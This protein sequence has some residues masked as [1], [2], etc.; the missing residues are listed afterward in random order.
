MFLPLQTGIE[1]QIALLV[2]VLII[3]F[4]VFKMMKTIKPLVINA[5]LGLVV[6]LL[7]GIVGFGVK[8]NVVL[9][10]LVAFGGVPAALLAIILAQ[11]GVVF[12]PAMLVPLF[13]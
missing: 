4:G 13:L 1:L 6:I 12:E 2:V 10:L 5:V 7:A 8:I 9:I 3:L 11:S